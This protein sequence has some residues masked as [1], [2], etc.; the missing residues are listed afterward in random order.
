MSRSR[1]L[2]DLVWQVKVYVREPMALFFILAF[3][4]VL[5][6]MAR[7]RLPDTEPTLVLALALSVSVAMGSF[8]GLAINL[9]GAIE[10]GILTRVY[11]TP[12]PL[13]LHLVARLL[14]PSFVVLLALLILLLAARIVLGLELGL[15]EGLGLLFAVLVGMLVFGSL[16][17]GLGSYAG[18]AD[19]AS[20]LTQLVLFPLILIEALALGALKGAAAPGALGLLLFLSPL[21]A[22]VGLSAGSGG[23]ERLF[24]G[25]SL[26]LWMVVG[27]A[28][29]ARRLKSVL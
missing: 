1:L 23:P 24:A 22:L 6:V 4:V 21:H 19:K 14:A 13:G 16:G 17:L 26:G 3:P 12:Q 20:F 8:A 28:Y 9:A 2:H 7:L 29:A 15:A 10:Q 5:L 25:V 18:R 27:L 11:V